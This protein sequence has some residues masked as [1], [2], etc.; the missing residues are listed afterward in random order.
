MAQVRLHD[1]TVKWMAKF[2]DLDEIIVKQHLSNFA[3]RGYKFDICDLHNQKIMEAIEELDDSSKCWRFCCSKT[4]PL[5]LKIYDSEKRTI[6]ELRRPYQFRRQRLLFNSPKGLK[7]GDIKQESAENLSFTVRDGAGK[8]VCIFVKDEHSNSFKIKT[9]EK[10]IG[11][12]QDTSHAFT[13]KKE[14][15]KVFTQANRSGTTNEFKLIFSERL[16]V[17]E[18]TLI[19]AGT[20]LADIFCIDNGLL[21]W[22]YSNQQTGA[23]YDVVFQNCKSN[24]SWWIPGKSL[25]L[26]KITPL[27]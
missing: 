19:L 8:E 11:K 15:T 5:V 4:R 7:L 1:E 14:G 6:M 16:S 26:N 21:R 17:S 9:Q 22:N 18:K 23:Y 25:T 10:E 13:E 24:R 27:F 20:F 3:V 12:I 2:D